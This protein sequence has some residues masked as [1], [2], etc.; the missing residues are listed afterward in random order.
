M[1]RKGMKRIFLANLSRQLL[2]NFYSNLT[3]ERFIIH[4]YY[5]YIPM[6][7]YECINSSLMSSAK[8]SKTSFDFI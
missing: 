3:G 5:I 1:F 2:C 4:Q 8:S 6:L 7:N